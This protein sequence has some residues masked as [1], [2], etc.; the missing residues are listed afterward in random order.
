MKELSARQKEILSFIRGYIDENGI[1][2]SFAEIAEAFSFSIP[3][4]H[5]AVEALVRKG[6][7]GRDGSLA[8]SI[9]L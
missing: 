5:Y 1:S 3:A 7:I 2:P 6:A 4:A 9:T 8:R